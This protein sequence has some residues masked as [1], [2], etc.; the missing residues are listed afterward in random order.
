MIKTIRDSWNGIFGILIAPNL[1]RT[2]IIVALVIGTLVGL[3]WGYGINPTVYYNGDPS[4]LE[5]SWQ[6][7]WVKMLADRYATPYNFDISPTIIDLLAK[8]DDPLGIVNALVANPAEAE[9]VPKLEALRPLAE[10]AQ[11]L[12]PAAPR[13]DDLF[14]TLQPFLVAPLALA[15]AAVI[16]IV[17][18][19]LLLKPALVDPMMK[20]LRGERTSKE[21]LDQRKAQA[22]ERQLLETQ[23]TDFTV[24]SGTTGTSLGVPLLQRMTTYPSMSGAEF[25]ESYEIEENEMFLGQCGVVYSDALDLPGTQLMAVEAWLFDKDDFVRT[26]TKVFVSEAVMNNPAQ[27]AQISA[28]GEPMLARTGA[29]IILDTNMLRA[30]A[31][32]VEMQYEP[33]GVPNAVFQR[34]VIE[35][36]AWH[37]T[38]ANAGQPVLMQAPV[39]SALPSASVQPTYNAPSAFNP[40]P[41]QP[42]FA[43]PSAQP[44][45]NPPPAQSFPSMPPAAPPRPPA[46][47]NDPFG[48]SGDFSPLG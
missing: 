42:A 21:V 20:I 37:K 29:T 15:I 24:V 46:Q 39:M 14:A 13:P 35:L 40:P 5:Q 2:A 47:D 41:A 22:Q 48:S 43:P 23:K 32:I 30:Q 12:A 44:V 45:Y 25:D 18:Y 33:G 28:K 11:P 26:Q 16:F 36:A 17:V 7:E 34:I 3:A 27:L 10:Q 31:R 9:N 19:N 1:P 4:S 6:N 38:G 8:V